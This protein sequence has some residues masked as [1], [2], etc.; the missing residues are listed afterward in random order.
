MVQQT[1]LVA[2][3]MATEQRWVQA[4]RELNV[5]DIEDILDDEY[6]RI[7]NGRVIGKEEVV[8]SYRS[9]KR[10]W[11]VADA[12][13]YTVRVAD[14]VALVVGEWRG[15]GLNHGEVFDYRARFLALYIRRD[16]GW[17]LFRDEYLDL[18]Q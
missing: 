16:S 5:A 14:D 1:E 18:K 17:K 15:V 8:D 12:S 9:G 7:K 13:N 4:H 11:A 6:K 3:V 10:R 2:D